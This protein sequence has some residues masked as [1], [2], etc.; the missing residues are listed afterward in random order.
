MVTCE[1]F[2]YLFTACCVPFTCIFLF[3][4]PCDEGDNHYSYLRDR[5]ILVPRDKVTCP[6]SHS[7]EREDRIWE[8][9]VRA[10]LGPLSTLL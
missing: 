9:T 5:K 10:E 6:K 4:R 3:I 8:G 2:Q 7:L 1:F